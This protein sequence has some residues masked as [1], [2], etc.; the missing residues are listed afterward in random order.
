MTAGV[1]LDLQGTMGGDAYGDITGFSF[2]PSTKPGLRLLSNTGLL[3]FIITNQSKIACG[4]ITQKQF[5][6][7][8]KELKKE[9]EIEGIHIQEIY[10]CPHSKE[11]MCICRKPSSFFPKIAAERFNLDLSRSFFIGDIYRSDI[12]MA[13]NVGATPI[14][15][16]TGKGEESIKILKQMN[17]TDVPFADDVLQAARIIQ[18]L[19]SKEQKQ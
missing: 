7:K 4:V 15:V 2:F 19:L 12:V 18:D 5:E 3:L 10:C 17:I 13:Q 11:D 6:D 9:L 16:R 8:A 1:F 14:L